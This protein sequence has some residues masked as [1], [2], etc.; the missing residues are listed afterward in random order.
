MVLIVLP[1]LLDLVKRSPCLAVE[2]CHI[3]LA[4]V[5]QIFPVVDQEK[6]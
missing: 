3:G 4:V 1:C 5:S 2:R 6:A